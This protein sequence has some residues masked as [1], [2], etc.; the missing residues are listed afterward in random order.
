LTGSRRDRGRELQELVYASR[1][2]YHA[3]DAQYQ[4]AMDS[5]AGES[6]PGQEVQNVLDK[7]MQLVGAK[8]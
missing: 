8:R 2:A 7:V 6:N 5:L 4:K 3:Q 1:V